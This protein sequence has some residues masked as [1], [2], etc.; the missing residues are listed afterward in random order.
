MKFQ[1]LFTEPSKSKNHKTR[2][3]AVKTL[4]ILQYLNKET[5]LIIPKNVSGM[6]FITQDNETSLIQQ[7]TAKC[8]IAS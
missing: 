5:H 7:H 8:F 3:K 2:H 4:A 1:N 6:V